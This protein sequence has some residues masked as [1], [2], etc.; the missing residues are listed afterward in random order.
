MG[1]HWRCSVLQPFKHGIWSLKRKYHFKWTLQGMEDSSQVEINE[2]LSG[3][4]E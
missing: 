2:E 1:T 3:Y 4:K